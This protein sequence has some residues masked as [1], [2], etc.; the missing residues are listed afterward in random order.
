MRCFG[1]T[2]EYAIGVVFALPTAHRRRRRRHPSRRPHDDD[3]NDDAPSSN[4]SDEDDEAKR[5]LTWAWPS[6]Y[7]AKTEFNIDDDGRL[8]NGREDALVSLSELRDM[9]RSYLHDADY[10][11][12]GRLV[13][14]GLT[15]VPYNEVYVRVGGVGRIVCGVDVC[16]GRACDDADGTG[17]SFDDG[18]NR[19]TIKIAI[20]S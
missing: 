4:F 1:S 7:S 19:C 17:R 3:D 5:T 18:K 14:G 8:I 16:T 6:G 12:G 13:V 11:V 20:V 2:S 9:N 10:V 15:T